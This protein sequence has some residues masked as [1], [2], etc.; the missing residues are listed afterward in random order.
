MAYLREKLDMLKNKSKNT[1]ISPLK[2]AVFTAAAAVT[3]SFGAVSGAS[4][5]NSKLT[6]VYY[7]YLNDTYIGTVSNKAVVEHV[8]DKKIEA[9]EGSYKDLNLSVGSQLKY[10]PEQVFRS[11]ANN[12]DVVNKLERDLHLQADAAAISVD[13]D[14][15]V[16]VQDK[17]MAE[18]V[19]K[20][21]KLKYVTAEQLAELEA[22]KASPTKVLPQLKENETRLLDVRFSKNVSVLDGK[23]EPT[24]ILSVKDA[25]AFLLKGTLEEKKYKV[26]EGDV[27][28]TIASAHDLRME[29]LLTLNPGLKE[30][31]V[32]DIG[33]EVNV[34]ELKPYVHVIVDKE[35]FQKEKIAFENEVVEDATMFKGDK[36]VKQ[37]GKDGMRAV[38]YVISEQ[39]GTVVKKTAAKEE[40]LEQPVNNIVI[41]GTKVVPS[42][43]DGK[44][45]WPTVGGYISS[46]MGYRWGK[47]HKG[48]DIAR[49]SDRT[50][51]TVDNGVVVSAGWDGGYGNKI[52]IDHQNGLRTVY[53]HLASIDVSAGQTVPKG[54]KIGVMGTTGDS[55]GIHL[56]FEVYKN[57]SLVNPMGYLK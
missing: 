49:P 46:Q 25:V 22:R 32:I 6:T 47:K 35:I 38:T 54:T 10:V 27:L 24:K 40:I 41:K 21:I 16:Y 31:S 36:K 29:Q 3:L 30:D 39:N 9:V 51:K 23:V 5:D 37:E 44:F 42:R 48:I 4:A 11:T 45:S 53:A 15:V 43:G 26:K 34:T 17:A 28:G 13:G 8:V 52:V 50:I 19:L 18:E 1:L 20:N 7:V 14:S 2:K 55:T 12:Q 33:K 56:H 57:G